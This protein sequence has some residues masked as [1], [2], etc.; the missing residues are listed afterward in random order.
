MLPLGWREVEKDFY[1]E[2]ESGALVYGSAAGFMD[3]VVSNQEF[4]KTRWRANKSATGPILPD[5]YDTK[6]LA[7]N[8]LGLGA[9]S[10]MN[11]S[12]LVLAISADVATAKNEDQ[13]TLKLFHWIAVIKDIGAQDATAKLVMLRDD[14]ELGG[15]PSSLGLNDIDLALFLTDLAAGR[16][17]TQSTQAA[18]L[19]PTLA[20]VVAERDAL[21]TTQEVPGKV[22]DMATPIDM[23]EAIETCVKLDDSFELSEWEEKFIID[24]GDKLKRGQRLS[25]KQTERLESIYDRT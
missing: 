6:E 23:I 7:M 18:L 25:E 16:V 24:I 20:R 9:I 1:Y 8:A 10:N 2:H 3:S 17:K 19:L 13:Q 15:Q 22:D 11:D 4:K 5:L 14:S 12:E 21:R